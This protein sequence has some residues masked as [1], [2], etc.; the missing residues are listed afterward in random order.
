MNNGRLVL[1]L[2]AMTLSGAAMCEENHLTLYAGYRAGGKLTDVGTGKDWQ[3]TDGGSIALGFGAALTRTTQFEVFISRRESAL[4]AS[5]FSPAAD[6]IGLDVT[7]AHFGG[8]FFPAGVGRGWYL[9]GGLGAT[10]LQ[11]RDRGFNSETRA[12]LS[13]AFGYMLPFGEHFGLKL[14][15]RGYGTLFDSSGGIFCSGGCVVQLS[16]DTLTQAEVLVGFSG[17]F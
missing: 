12:S 5:G 9:A 8:T 2:V 16:G 10:E 7:Y 14:E 3:L 1:A 6:N 13:L 11:P 15:A 4:K 17:R